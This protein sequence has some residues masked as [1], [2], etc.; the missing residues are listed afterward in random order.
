MKWVPNFILYYIIF[1]LGVGLIVAAILVGKNNNIATVNATKRQARKAYMKADYKDAFTELKFLV[2][3]LQFTRDEARLNLAHS[4]YLAS[5][6]DST[7]NVA[8]DAT[9]NGTPADTTAL[10][11]MIGENTYTTAVENYGRVS[12]SEKFRLASI[13]Y[14]QMGI[15]TYTARDVEEESKE[16]EAMVEAANYFKSALKKDPGN[17]F[18]RYNYELL[19]KRIQYPEA[20]MSRVRSLVHQRKYKEA[21]QILHG[22][23]GRD[24]RMQKNYSDYVQRLENVISI[25]SL[26]RS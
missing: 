8:R 5:R 12:E 22:A 25:D 17:E 2:D 15:T 16:D 1:I 4:G 13:A 24:S 6:F 10:K 21:R 11:K 26:S 3:T 14:N 18:A 7:G 19:R 9:K 23:L 20:V